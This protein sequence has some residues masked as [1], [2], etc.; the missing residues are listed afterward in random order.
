M[1]YLGNS[2]F[3]AIH[4]TQALTGDNTT[5]NFQLS[6]PVN[7]VSDILVFIDSVFQIPGSAYTIVGSPYTYTLHFTETPSTGS[8]ISVQWLS[9]VVDQ[10]FDLSAYTNTTGMNTAIQAVPL[11]GQC[12]LVLS[13]GNLLLKPVQG[14]RIVINGTQ[15]A[16]PSAG[17]SLAPAGLTPST[18]YY[19]YAYMNSG[20]MTLEASATGHST[21]TVNGVEIKTGDATRSFVGWAYPVTGPA[22]AD[23]ATQR[24]VVSFFNRR[25]KELNGAGTAGATTTSTT[26]VELTTTARVQFIATGDDA[27]DVTVSGYASNGTGGQSTETVPG[28]DGSAIGGTTIGTSATAGYFSSHASRSSSTSAEGYHYVT[29]LGCVTGGTGTFTVSIIGTIRG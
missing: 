25:A 5:V 6:Y 23:S 15:Q 26:M 22:F 14:N 18:L 11:I 29:P 12:R 17:V 19:I 9:T 8:V 10:T 27:Y 13:G 16:I 21:S 20:T 7:T 28:V 4:A 3:M 24:L 2:A 1:S